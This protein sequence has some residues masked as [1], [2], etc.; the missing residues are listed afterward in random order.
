MEFWTFQTVRQ[1]GI[2]RTWKLSRKISNEGLDTLIFSKQHWEPIFLH[3]HKTFFR[4]NSTIV[5]YT[6]Q[7]HH[8]KFEYQGR[9]LYNKIQENRKQHRYQDQIFFTC[10]LHNL[11]MGFKKT[12]NIKKKN[13]LNAAKFY[14]ITIKKCNWRKG[15][16]ASNKGK[17]TYQKTRWRLLQ[18]RVELWCL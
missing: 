4:I 1:K 16:K 18:N 10:L 8:S 7:I 2:K 13:S 14:Q 5:K 3:L 9:K 17:E 15:L 6:K 11:K 12:T